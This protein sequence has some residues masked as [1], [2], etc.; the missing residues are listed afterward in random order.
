MFSGNEPDWLKKQIV[1]IEVKY[2]D[3][4]SKIQTGKIVCNKY[5][6]SKLKRIFKKLLEI[7][8]PIYSIIPISE[9]NW[10]DDL[11]CENNNTSCFNYR[12]V[13]GTDF[14]SDHAKGLAIDIN[15]VQNPWVNPKYGNLPKGSNYDITKKGTITEDIA[16]IFKEDGFKWGGDWENSDYQHFYFKI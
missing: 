3:F 13:K 11:S 6:S 9:F 1:E 8:F 2:V 5:I 16:N 14:L 4:E 15:P 10:N 7:E 12:K